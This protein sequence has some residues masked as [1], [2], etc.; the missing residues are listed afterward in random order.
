MTKNYL[1]LLFILIA[2]SCSKKSD[3]QPDVTIDTATIELKYD[4]QHQFVLTK[5]TT[6]VTA[7]TFTWMSSDTTV[8]SISKDG[9]FK[10]RKIGETKITAKGDGK[11]IEAKVTVSPTS[12][13]TTEPV[14]DWGAAKTQ[15]KA[16]EK[17]ALDTET[18]STLIY[19]GENTKVSYAAYLVGGSKLSTSALLLTS[20]QAVA[21]EAITFF[22]ERYPNFGQVDDASVGFIDD[23][24]RFIIL[25]GVDDS[26][27]LY[28][29][30]SP[31]EGTLRKSTNA[32]MTKL[33]AL[34]LAGPKQRIVLS[35]H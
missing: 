32:A 24:A 21:S 18:D 19:T 28:A 17:R 15:I 34:K 11:T 23:D 20:T 2:A 33:K 3:L 27:G 4:G 5:G 31:F 30:Y 1:L 25:L 7:S 6:A 16:K 35:A 9:N 29:I 26:L 8:G 14:T 12:T 22:R 13:L 10:A